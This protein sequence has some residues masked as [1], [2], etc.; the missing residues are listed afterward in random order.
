[1]TEIERTK[2]QIAKVEALRAAAADKSSQWYFDQCL[3]GWR[4]HLAKL[5]RGEG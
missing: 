2:A 4:A 1:M 3:A 5:E